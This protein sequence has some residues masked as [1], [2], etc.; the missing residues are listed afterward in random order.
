MSTLEKM[1]QRIHRRSSARR[2]THQRK[3][4]AAV[5]PAISAYP[6]EALSQ[7]LDHSCRARC[8]PLLVAPSSGTIFPALNPPTMRRLMSI[9]T[10]SALV[11]LATY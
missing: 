11:S 2:Q 6:D 3:M 4:A 10:L 9:F 8:W 1:R 5:D 7:A